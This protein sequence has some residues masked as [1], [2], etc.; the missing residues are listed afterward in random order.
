MPTGIIFALLAM[1]LWGF[2]ELYL[3]Q[4]I[5]GLRSVTTILINSIAGGLLSLFVV[6]PLLD[7]TVTLISR[8]DFF[9]AI[10]TAC[11]AFI[12]YVFFYL[13]LERQELSLISSFDESWIVITVLIAVVGFGEKISTINL[14]AIVAVLLGAFLI[15]VDFSH[16][17]SPHFIAGS[18]YAALAVLFTGFTVPLEAVLVRAIGE[19]NAI[20]YMYALYFPLIL[21]MKWILRERLVKPT[22]KLLRISALSGLAD[23]AAFAFY[24]LAI[25]STDV[26]IVAP[27]VASSVVVAVI[28]ARVYLKEK[29]TRK[30]ILGTILVLLGVVGV[31]VAFGA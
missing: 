29:M 16:I 14:T 13:A 6:L 12:G 8:Q 7:S 24:L 20:V 27:I 5:S 4:A 26:S 19:A 3:K 10:L 31:S 2:E 21:V 18:G 17:R 23:G 22:K 15:S 9:F 25:N 28:L 30:E 1:V 11:V